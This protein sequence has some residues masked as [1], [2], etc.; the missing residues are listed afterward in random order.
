[1]TTA[2]SAAVLKDPGE[3]LDYGWDYSDD[4]ALTP[5][6]EIVTSVWDVPAGLTHLTERDNLASPVTIFWVAGGTVGEDYECENTATDSQGRIYVRTIRI[7]VR[8]K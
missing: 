5:G 6:A 7:F 4:L 8:N 3:T 2:I 1:M